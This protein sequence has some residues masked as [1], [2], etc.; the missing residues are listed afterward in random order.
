LLS[1]LF[2]NLETLEIPEYVDFTSS[3]PAWPARAALRRYLGG[4]VLILYFL[5]PI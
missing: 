3:I 2:V 5:A 1:R 4:G